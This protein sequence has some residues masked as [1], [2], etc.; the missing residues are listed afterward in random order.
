MGQILVRNLPDR[1]IR[2]FKDRAKIKGSS[3]EQEIRELIESHAGLTPAEKMA[4][5]RDIRSRQPQLSEP[6]TRDEIREGLE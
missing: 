6:M 1:V 5:S 3:L 4:I 2:A